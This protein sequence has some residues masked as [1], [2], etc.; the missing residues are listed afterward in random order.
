MADPDYEFM[1]GFDKY[2]RPSGSGSTIDWVQTISPTDWEWDAI[3]S[4]I[5]IG[6]PIGSPR[7]ASI[8]WTNNGAIIKNLPTTYGRV[9]GSCCARANNASSVLDFF[10]CGL[11]TTNLT[12]QWN[13]NGNVYARR[14]TGVSTI[15]ATG[16]GPMFPLVRGSVHWFA[17]DIKQAN[18]DG[19]VKVWVDG[20]LVINF[21]GDTTSA[22]SDGTSWFQLYAYSSN[23]IDHFWLGCYLTAGGTETP[24]L[25]NPVIETNYAAS[26]SA[27]QFTP[28]CIGLGDF[29]RYSSSYFANN[30]GRRYFR[31]VRADV[32]G[33]LTHINTYVSTTSATAN[34]KVALYSDSGGLPSTVLGSSGS[35]VGTTADTWKS[36][37][38]S[39]PVAITAG[40]YYWLCVACDTAINLTETFPLS[41][42]TLDCPGCYQT[43]SY[44]SAFGN[45]PTVVLTD[46]LLV[47]ATISGVS[48]N[49]G[50]VRDPGGAYRGRGSS[51]STPINY[52]FSNTPGQ[53]DLFTPETLPGV[54]TAI[55]TV[56][57][58]AFTLRTDAGP[59]TMDLRMKSG[60][61]SSSGSL[62]G[63][64]PPV[65]SPG[66][67][68]SNFRLNPDGS[69]A[70][71]QTTLNNS[72]FGYKLV[73]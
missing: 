2:G 26:D 20:T 72:K 50:A 54:P 71:T 66:W 64:T 18:S 34:I 21:S 47:Y 57:I 27:V 70:W 69:V 8:Y 59:R 43:I 1:D 38:L 15:F 33:N 23:Y 32:S 61:V 22:A 12:L 16:V 31:R 65:T 28:N 24:P 44:A 30:T 36:V 4:C 42:T 73:T 68:A 13:N 39:A 45:S 67:L 53:E 10:E 48:G 56:Q 19:Y 51:I 62:A 29:E 37:A 5:A 7:G 55:H 11:G 52:N 3:D 63:Q 40:T 35:S 9:M 14:G 46:G 60:A 58:K 17:W 6:P 41:D 49:F 25:T